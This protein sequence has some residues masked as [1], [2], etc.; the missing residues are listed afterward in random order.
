MENKNTRERS[1]L[2]EGV[3]NIIQAKHDKYDGANNQ[4]QMYEDKILLEQQA[5][6]L[7]EELDNANRCLSSRDNCIS[8]LTEE[9]QS[10]LNFVKSLSNKNTRLSDEKRASE[11]TL[12]E[13]LEQVASSKNL[14]DDLTKRLKEL[15]RH[16]SSI[17]S[18]SNIAKSERKESEQRNDELHDEVSSLYI[19]LKQI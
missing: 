19:S 7:V 6:L 8:E 10:K 16:Q 13:S 18:E 12:L 15:E 3:E 11:Q 5:E 9:L 1:N 4:L 14:A 17:V 2:Q